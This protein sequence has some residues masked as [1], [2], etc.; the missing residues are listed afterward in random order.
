MKGRHISSNIRLVIDLVQYSILLYG[1]PLILFLDFRKTFDTV[2]HNFI[3]DSWKLFGF[4]Q[5][6]Q[7]C[8]NYVLW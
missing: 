6:H 1:D 8:K 5:F 7:K 2:S 3:F 4:G